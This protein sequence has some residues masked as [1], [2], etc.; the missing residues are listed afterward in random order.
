VSIALP[1]EPGSSTDWLDVLRAQGVEAVRSGI[2]GAEPFK[3]TAG[4]QAA[5]DQEQD[6]QEELAEIAA[7]YPLPQ[8]DTLKL[9]YG[10]TPAG[11]VKAHKVTKRKVGSEYEEIVMPVATPFGVVARLRYLDQADAYGLRAVVQDMSGKPRLIDF[12]RG[13]LARTGG[14]DIRSLFFQVGLRTEADGEHIAVQAI[15]A[16]DPEQEI[17]VV[18]KGG[19]HELAGVRGTG[20]CVP[21]RRDHRGLLRATLLNFPSQRGSRPRFPAWA[22]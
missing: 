4:E 16:A 6:Q 10:F 22:L 2:M 21:E 14:A 13:A 19:W 3:A 9:I 1:G 12:D 7:T 18:R 17:L 5:H 11:K 15:K 8:L 20:V